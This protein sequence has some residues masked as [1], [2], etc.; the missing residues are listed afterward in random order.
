MKIKITEK[1]IFFSLFYGLTI[2]N[3]IIFLEMGINFKDMSL[4]YEEL[5]LSTI[6]GIWIFEIVR[7]KSEVSDG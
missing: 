2:F 4:F 5:I 7:R 6:I 1:I 3:L